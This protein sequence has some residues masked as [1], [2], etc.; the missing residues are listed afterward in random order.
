MEIRSM[1]KITHCLENSSMGSNF[2]VYLE[3]TLYWWI[4]LLQ[5]IQRNK[6]KA[7]YLSMK[8]GSLFVLFCFVSMRFTKWG[9]FRLCSWCLWK[10][11]N[12]EG[13]AWAW[14]MT[15]RL[16]MQKLLNIKWFFQ[17]KFRRNWNVPLV[18]FERSW[19]AGFNGIYLV[20]FGF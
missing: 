8:E 2:L 10:A 13:C 19:W 20:R 6:Q 15:F 11:L 4:S 1:F 5:W 3:G 12:E 18:L 17:W 16:V 9:C 14:S 7:P